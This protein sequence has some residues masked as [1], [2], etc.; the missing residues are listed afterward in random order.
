M[1]KALWENQ[2]A[3]AAAHNTGKAMDIKT[4]LLGIGVAPVHAGAMKYYEEYLADYNK[5]NGTSLSF[6]EFYGYTK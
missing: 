1:T 6:A 2:A 4:A 3:I 5:D